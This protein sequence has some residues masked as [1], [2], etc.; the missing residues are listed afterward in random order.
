[1]MHTS[2]PILPLSIRGV[3]PAVIQEAARKEFEKRQARRKLIDFTSYTN[4]GYQ[5]ARHNELIA[6]EVDAWISGECPN[7]MILTPPRHGKTELVSRRAPGFI[8]GKFPQAQIIATSYAATL[9]HDNSLKAKRIMR[10][11]E[12]R[13]LFP[14]VR[15]S[16][17]RG[18][19]I[20]DQ[21]DEWETSAGGIYKCAGV[22]GGITGKGFDFGI[23]DDP[24]KD[25]AEAESETI[26]KSIWDWYT[27]TF[28]TRSMPN[29]RK[30]LT[31]TPWHE[32]DLAGRLIRAME[33]D[34]LADQWRI[35][36]LPAV[37]EAGDM[38]GR[39]PGEA[40]WPAWFPVEKLESIKA[41]IGGY[42]WEA[43]YQTR[44]RKP[45]GTYI[46]RHWF[47]VDERAP[48]GLRWYRYWDLAVSA[49][50]TADYT[51]SPA[52]AIDRDG[53]IWIRD[54]VRGQWEWPIARKNIVLTA[55]TERGVQ[56]GVE[57]VGT[58]KGL[59]QDLQ[60]MD[61]LRQTSIVPIPT[62]KD[63]L[64]RAL[65][66]IARAEAGKVHLLRGQWVN[67]FL[68][69]CERFT[70]RDGDG[71]DDQVDGVSGAY[72]MATGGVGQAQIQ[73][74][75]VSGMRGEMKGF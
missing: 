13:D 25:R 41:V 70:G 7:L 66:W 57:D 2:L 47:H 55:K 3:H 17:K 60:D 59:V 54:M 23:I 4:A 10:T 45:G 8:F 37:A 73:S 64:T 65:P 26:R 12:Y 30:L 69:E 1:M 56:V 33:T 19:G 29:S 22:G 24:V 20:L 5:R 72:V 32:D 75:S 61:D 36:R 58:Q 53:G 11:P 18:D 44:P 48:E 50:K 63:K 21:V 68:D 31:M 52:L 6:A 9:A 46:Q 40:L 49:K 14:N 67:G 16:E 38:L 27:S 15:L 42:D 43:L 71:H 35:V 39:L 74:A 51:A 62:D 28:F 34:P